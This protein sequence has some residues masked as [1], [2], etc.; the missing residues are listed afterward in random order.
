MKKAYTKYY[1]S[2]L[3]FGTNGI[4]AS[5]IALSSYEI[6]LLRTLI[7][8]LSLILIAMLTKTKI[9]FWE[10]KQ[11]FIYL[12]ISGM[13]MG[14]SWMFLYEAYQ[15]IGVSMASLVYY[16]GPIIV[17]VLSPIVFKEKLTIRKILCFA[18]GF[19]GIFL[20][21]GQVAGEGKMAWGIFCGL[22]SAVTYA[23]MLIF[24]KKVKYLT[25][26]ENT[27]MQ[28]VIA[29]ATVAIFVGEKQ[30][31][32][33]QISPEDILPALILGVLNT[34][35]GCYLYFSSIGFL[36]VQTVAITG[37]IEPLAAVIFSTLFLK[38]IMTPIQVLGAVLVLGGAV[39]GELVPK[40]N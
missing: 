23:F 15:Q 30:G 34:G 25:G 5:Y 27:T 21:N 35:F 4:V 22:M 14:A 39:L 40:S 3:L 18:I 11:E 31:I 38:E 13:A 32:V 7:G 8:S 33:F 29:F 36:P 9:K 12:C 26:L 20:I 17:M 6:V 1:L 16:C 2:L 24:N 28:V 19:A 37:Y 10:N